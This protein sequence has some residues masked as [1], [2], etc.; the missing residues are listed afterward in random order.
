MKDASL[1]ARC[2]TPVL[3]VLL[4]FVNVAA[5]SADE[6][7]PG[8]GGTAPSPTAFPVPAGLYLVTDIYAGDVVTTTGGTTTYATL[9]VSASP[10]TFARVIDSVATGEASAYDGRSFNGRA[11]LSDG[12]LVAGTYYETFV[13][14]ASGYVP[15]NIVF[16]QSDSETRQAAASPAPSA[17]P[18][19]VPVTATSAPPP[20]APT[21]MPTATPF[22]ATPT[23]A[24]V[25]PITAAG[26]ALGPTAPVLASIEVLRGRLVQLYPRAF[27]DGRPVAVRSWRL[28]AGTVD[29]ASPLAG[30][31]GP[32]GVS[33]LRLAPVGTAWNLHFEVTTDSAPGLVLIA[34]IA[35]AVRSP[36]LLE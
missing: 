25:S 27:V 12:R 9:T 22:I 10:G 31:D 32:C 5:T 2:V 3:A 29:L 24:P 4:L 15:V 21:A 16:F 26:V 28:V 34:S 13:L 11:I 14:T 35:V 8:G 19:A 6:L 23:S 7:D 17:G 18:T 30:A 33:W 1:A 20:P 36:A